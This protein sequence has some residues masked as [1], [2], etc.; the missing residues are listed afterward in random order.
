[1]SSYSLPQVLESKLQGKQY[2]WVVTGVAGFIG[3][4]LLETLLSKNQFVTG[5]DNFATG[6]KENLEDVK[7]IVGEEA[8]S[9]FKFIEGTILDAE[10]CNSVCKDADFVLHQAALG[11]V[12]RSVTDPKRYNDSNVAGFLNMLIAARDSKVKKF[13]YASSSSVYGDEP[14]LPKREERVGKALSPYALTKWMNELYARLFSDLYSIS[15]TGLRYFNVFGPRQDPKGEYAAVIPRWVTERLSGEQCTIFGDGTTSR[16]FCYVTN[17]VQANLLAA[18][19]DDSKGSEAFNVALGDETSLTELYNIIDEAV[20]GSANTVKPT[21]ADFRVGDVK[22][23]KADIS[24]IQGRLGFEPGIK[25]KE[26]L[27]MVVD[28][29]RTSSRKT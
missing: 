25:V 27:A 6:K 22:H 1:M 3:S 19:S 8:F 4:H 9:R 17:V 29:Y 24:Q 10:L 7:R 26:G 2:R 18:F 14:N 21:Y 15:S 20:S 5:L 23:S 13:V 28:W 11:S 16:D 12:A